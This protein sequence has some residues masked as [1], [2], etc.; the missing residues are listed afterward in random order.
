[1]KDEKEDRNIK[2]G[3]PYLVGVILAL[4]ASFYIRTGS[5]A[6]VI[7]S[8]SFVRFGGND[9]WYHMRVVSTILHNYPHNLWFDAYTLYPSGQEMV[10]APL[11]D[12]VLASLIF[13]LTL[14]NHS[15]HQM[16]VIGAYFP[17]I[18]GTLVVIPTYYA[19]KWI[20]NRNVGLLAAILIAILPGAFLHRS[21][22]GFTDHHVAET[23]MSTVTAMFLIM[24]L[25]TM[26]E[27]PVYFDDIM[28]K[29]LSELKHSIGYIALMG[30]S[31][32]LYTLAWKGALFF[33]LIIG[34]YI[35]IQHIIDH[36]R[37]ENTEYLAIIGSI[38]FFVAWLFVLPL[39]DLGG[40]YIN[41]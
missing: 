6:S 29:D 38:S 31:M 19:G 3:L 25:K 30:I 11:Y 37:N 35:T 32:G 27:H 4:M 12:W 36:L 16:E 7:L 40:H 1:M 24:A 41:T 34:V 17:A 22:L 23:L 21:L 10:F 14:G 26:R 5:K 33:A 28:A 15:V 20:F 13:V 9:P 39:P 18:L 2:N 8:E